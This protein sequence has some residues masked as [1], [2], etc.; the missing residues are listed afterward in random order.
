MQYN[1]MP[2]DAHYNS[3]FGAVACSFFD[4]SRA[5]KTAVLDPAFFE[6]L[7]HSYLSGIQS[8]CS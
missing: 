5:L 1:M 4:A 3:G 6:H 8:N 2:L 7:P